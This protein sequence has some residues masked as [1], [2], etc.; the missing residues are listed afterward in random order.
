ME[1]NLNQGE[2]N[3]VYENTAS[4][5]F[6]QG[7]SKKK[8][9][10][11]I[12]GAFVVLMLVFVV[13]LVVLPRFKSSKTSGNVT[14]TYW[15]IWEDPGA[16]TEIADEFTRVHPN[17]K[18]KYEKKDIKGEG[19]FMD[20]LAARMQDGTGPDVFRFHNSWV[21]ELKGMM[22][23]LPSDLVSSSEIDTKYYNVIKR[24][25]NIGGAYYGIPIHMDTLALY[26]NSK[27][28]K[29][30]GITT[31]PS[32]WEDL[33]NISRQVVVKDADGRIT[34]AGVALGTFDNISHASDIVSLLMVQDGADL[35]N[36]GGRTKE[37][38]S[39]ALDYYSA[40][41]K[42]DQKV[43]DEK[44]DNS[45]LAF[46]KGNLALYFGYSWDIFEIKAINPNLE[47]V[48]I[49][50]PRITP[51]KDKTIASYWVEGV[52]AKSKHP[53]EAFEFLKFLTSKENLEKLYAKESKLRFFG[54]IY[55]RRDMQD[56]LKTNSLISPF[57]ERADKAESTPFSS[58]TY[59]EGMV[60][61][62]NKYMA[63]AVNSV[64]ENTSPSSAIETLGKGV[65]DILG[66]YA[67]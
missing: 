10:S 65:S 35:K 51:E 38:A 52:S 8:I 7:S 18:I 39:G 22:L 23:P 16:I 48:V 44:M 57:L 4:E 60:D 43:W 47:F 36:L 21:P 54:E 50:V 31:Y 26:V 55:P 45:K 6:D 49:P 64:H 33:I 2:E 66:R 27:I 12:I 46:G 25:L 20:R 15:G 67:K 59:D 58:D 17:I 53:T 42:G 34:T 62:L 29:D 41:A 3:V 13:L 56:F 19:K 1:E 30:A 28:L 32:S 5:D 24:D 14:L 11:L 40:F 9:I 63:D 61:S 37:V